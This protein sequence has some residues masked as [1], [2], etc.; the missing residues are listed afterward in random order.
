MPRTPEKEPRLLAHRALWFL[1]AALLLAIS[2]WCIILLLRSFE[3]RQDLDVRRGWIEDMRHLRQELERPADE[4]EKRRPRLDGLQ[5]ASEQLARGGP[6]ESG[7]WES[8]PPHAPVSQAAK[9][10]S[11]NLEHLR[12]ALDDGAAAE[13]VAGEA[14]GPDSAADAEAQDEAARERV[15]DASFAVLKAASALEQRIDGQI[16]RIYR[17]LDEH[18][19]SLN[20]LLVVCVLLCGSNLGLLYLA[21][22][23][24]QQLEVARDRALELASHDALTGLWNRDAILKMLRRE[25]ARSKRLRTPLGVVLADLDD[26]QQINGLIGQDQGDLVLQEV[27]WRLGSLVRPYDTL[28]RFDGDSFLAL[29]PNCDALACRSVGDRL[30]QAVNDQDVEYGLGR[31]AVQA[32]VVV[33]AVDKAE[34]TDADLLL[35][36]LQE[37]LAE[38]RRSGQ[39]GA[40]AALTDS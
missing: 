13:S 5:R 1:S 17:R 14:G 30:R 35:H 28:G 27:A 21:Q 39:S 31:L 12:R 36:R 3:L 10:L 6:W 37:Q 15:W 38:F 4:I 7:P 29:L 22:R 9:R 40:F 2:T 33:V 26:F 18:W 19:R 32:S 11:S 16:D 8:G 20:L 24:R 23:R 34:D 25:L